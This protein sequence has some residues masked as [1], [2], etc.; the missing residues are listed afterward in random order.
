MLLDELEQVLFVSVE[1][2]SDDEF[3]SLEMVGNAGATRT[4][5]EDGT[6]NELNINL[7][8]TTSINEHFKY[9]H[10]STDIFHNLLGQAVHL[11]ERN[12]EDTDAIAE[13]AFCPV[14]INATEHMDD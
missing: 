7:M 10:W 4:G 2:E 9:I 11:D 1:L 8:L 14:L 6:L 12:R 5:V 3:E 13:T